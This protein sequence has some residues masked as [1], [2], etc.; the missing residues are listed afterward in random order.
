MA[1][2]PLPAVRDIH[3][4]IWG[5]ASGAAKWD[6]ATWD[7]AVWA[8]GGVWRDV[9]PEVM[10]AQVSWGVDDAVGVLSVSA[11]GSWNLRT[12]DPQ[13]KLDPANPSSDYA[14]A[15]RPG[16]PM[17]LTY[18]DA[19]GAEVV[20]RTGIIDE[21]EFDLL[22]LTGTLRGSDGVAAMVAAR[23]P[24]I[25]PATVGVP[26][27][28]RARAEYMIA[29]AGLAVKVSDESNQM[30][31]DPSF[32]TMQGWALNAALEIGSGQVAAGDA[33]DGDYILRMIGGTAGYPKYTTL[34]GTRIIPGQTY[35]L[36]GWVRR[37]VANGA[38]EPSIRLSERNS[39][40]G[41]VADRLVLQTPN[42]EWT[43]LEGEWT[44]PEDG[45]AYQL[46]IS[47][48]LN[49]SNPS[50]VTGEFDLV[51]LEALGEF[52]DPQV[53]PL[54][55]RETTLW[56][57]ILTDAYDCLHA[58]WLDSEGL[59]RFRSFG[60]PI[61]NGVQI[62]GA[63]GIAIET[64]KSQASMQDIHSR[65]IAY[66]VTAPDVEVIKTDGVSLDKYGETFLRRQHPVPNAAIWA[67]NVLADR[68]GAAL[69][70]IPG[71][72]RPQTPEQLAQL[73][74]LGMVEIVTIIVES[75]T[76]PINIP[77]RV[78]GG[79]IEANTASG[80][81]AELVTYVPAK[82]WEDAELPPPI[83]PPVEPPPQQQTVVRT[84]AV[85][86]DTRAARSSGG[87]NY[88][89][90]TEGELPVGA[91]SGWRNR[92]FIDF[93]AIPWGDVLSV[94]KAEIDLWTSSQVNIGF[95]SSPK[96][97]VQRVTGAWNEGSLSSPGSGNSTVYPGPPVTSSGA[98]S[99]TISK[100]EGVKQ[101]IDITAI[102]RAWAP[103]TAGGNGQKQYGIGI[104]SAGEDSTTYTTEFWSR[105]H[106]TSTDPVLR[107][108]VKVPA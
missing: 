13:R 20:L 95:G 9:T 39:S 104:F 16:Q 47:C 92:A 51:Q 60:A 73:V 22:S 76:P 6:S 54:E 3:I 75:V 86:K 43:F 33:K 101:T 34:S 41:M 102:V 83:E 8:S 103:T 50:G 57:Q 77:V 56:S 27:T 97:K 69:Q 100:S 25:D 62:G 12:Y 80:W 4:Y 15:L 2:P 45:S 84:Y 108:T 71:I 17:R 52:T 88:G 85:T 99:K 21:I 91:W 93:A 44:A 1:L 14:V 10:N 94:D 11:A 36:S 61:D 40:G 78:L 29:K 59:L 82:E 74:N 96:V 98:V 46:D 31:T 5:P 32:E 63:D 107:V 64:I 24:P 106:G 90:G 53:G 55:G 23:L 81:S 58:V 65:V 79:R 28:L 66:D 87:A 18:H 70:Y 42:S 67:G 48:Q 26:N 38:L 72:I 30:V 49:A 89:S 35:R 105:E 19:L 7:G 68:A 37:T